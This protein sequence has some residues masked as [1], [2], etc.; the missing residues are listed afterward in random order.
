Y[1]D[2][3]ARLHNK[4][5]VDDGID[6]CNRLARDGAIMLDPHK[7]ADEI[8]SAAVALFTA[9]SAGTK[10]PQTRAKATEQD[11]ETVWAKMSMKGLSTSAIEILVK[12][13]TANPNYCP[14]L[15]SFL[16]AI[17][18]L[19]GEQGARVRADLAM[20]FAQK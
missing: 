14:S 8:T 12:D 16:T 19:D 1:L 18:S 6:A 17:N 9:I 20:S 7:Y 15:L 2:T 13:D 11:W 4:V 3:V 5:L 10:T